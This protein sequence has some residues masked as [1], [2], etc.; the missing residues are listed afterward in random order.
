[1]CRRA[2]RARL[3]ARPLPDPA[4][5]ESIARTATG[6]VLYATQPVRGVTLP[7]CWTRR[8]WRNLRQSIRDLH[9]TVVDHHDAVPGICCLRPGLVAHRH[10][11]EPVTVVQQ[12]TN[13]T[14][15]LPLLVSHNARRIDAALRQLKPN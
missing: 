3:H 2:P 14:A 9:A 10:L 11:R 8:E 15:S 6:R 7:D 13:V 4:D 1:M 5:P 12:A